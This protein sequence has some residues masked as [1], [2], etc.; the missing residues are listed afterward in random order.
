[1]L[2]C[3]IMKVGRSL[4]HKPIPKTSRGEWIKP[5][6]FFYWLLCEKIGKIS[7]RVR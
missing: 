6:A 4:V 2:F 5:F 1:M 7:L 3:A